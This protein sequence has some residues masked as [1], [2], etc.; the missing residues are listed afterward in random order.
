MDRMIEARDPVTGLLPLHFETR[1]GKLVATDHIAAGLDMGRQTAGLV[2]TAQLAALQ[3]DKPRAERY[4]QAAEENYS[5]GQKLLADGDVFVQRRDFNEDGT[6]KFSERGEPGK[7]AAGEDNM[8]RV[9]PRG[10]AFRG[11]AELFLATAKPKYKDDFNRYF[12]AW[13]RDFHDPAEGGFFLHSNLDQAGDHQERS[14]FKAPGGG[15]SNYDGKAG[16]KGNDGTIYA[17][18]GV[19]LAA[20]EVLATPQT[21]QLVKEQMDLIL[22]KFQRSN[23][24]LWENYQADF[25]PLSQDWQSQ[26]REDGQS[27]HV[28]IGGHTAMASQQIIEGARQLKKQGVLDQA[29]YQSYI[30]RTVACFQDFASQSGA[31]DWQSGAV[32]NAIRVEEPDQSKRWISNWG[33]A[34]WQ[35]AELI[36]S[37][38]RLKEEGRLADI[39]GPNGLNG[40]DLLLSAER[41]YQDRYSQSDSPS[42]KDYFGNPDVYHVPQVALYLEQTR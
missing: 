13:V 22:D 20:N 2:M 31:V 1:D 6:V 18:S 40:Q 30:D 37:L 33:D 24:M 15:E 28:A 27:S 11:A 41:H 19:L 12:Q 36:Q 10:Y 32:H 5:Q 21:Q 35:Q 23:G 3:G 29:Q 9:N 25:Q 38:V 26:P 42:F 17:M 39:H 7:S 4:L 34:S 8:S 16:A 14:A